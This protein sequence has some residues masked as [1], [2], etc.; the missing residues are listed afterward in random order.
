MARFPD[1]FVW[2]TATAAYQIEGAAHEDGRG[3]SIWDTF[4]HT[5]GK[6]A[7]GDTGD[8]ACD[9]YHRY[10]DDVALMQQLGVQAYRFSIAWPR[11]L[12]HGTGE[13]N[14]AGLNFYD[15]LVDTLLAANITPF[16]TLYHWDLPQA[17][18]DE[19]GWTNR[20]T[21]DAFAHYTDVV[22]RRLGDRVKH[23]ITLNEPW[24]SAFL[25]H[26]LGQ[27]A[28]GTR[29]YSDALA[30]AHTLLLAH[31]KAVPVLRAA[32]PDA[33]V[34]ITLNLAPGLPAT[35][36]P[37]DIEA[38]QRFDGFM[39]RWFLNPVYG[40]GYPDDVS[41]WY[42]FFMPKIEDGDLETIAA[43]LDFLGINYYF[44]VGVRAASLLENPLRF[45]NMTPDE[46]VAQGYE[47]TAMDWPIVPQGLADLLARVQ[48]D[49]APQTIYITENGAAFDDE[50]VDGQIHDERRLAYLREHFQAAHQAIEAGVPLRGYFVWSFMDNF[51]WAYGYD[52]R[53]GI[54][55][56][57][58][59]TQQ[60]TPKQSAHWYQQVI[61]ANTVED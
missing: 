36:D 30:A 7:N 51:E 55:H 11:I 3:A 8:V 25:G 20:T 4:S 17:L 27:H 34:G 57:D 29:D 32:V 40:H 2:G 61:A 21:A 46:A 54:V 28:P 12:P 15:K 35:D 24:C 19:G 26:A 31:G 43:P 9:H 14:E 39:N 50:V 48:R 13:V 47:M 53:F 49:Y 58:Y 18:Q 38:V 33:Q 10:P 52:K 22:A 56:V 23:W 37:N 45:A 42:R 44:P 59:P 1:G 5:P 6:T 16:V 60:R 41:W